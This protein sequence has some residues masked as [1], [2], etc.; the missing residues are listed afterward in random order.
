MLQRQL[1]HLN[2]VSLTTARFKPLILSMIINPFWVWVLYYDRRSVCL[3][4]K[5][6]SGAYDEIFI[7]SRQLWVCWC[8][9]LS[10]MRGRVCRWLLLLALA[11]FIFGSESHGTR[12]HIL[13]SQNRD[14]LFRRLLRLAGL[15]WRYSNPPPHGISIRS[16]LHGRLYSL[17]VT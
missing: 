4:I 3:G 15:R 13:L 7:T 12:D 5:H 10:L 6:P 11:I 2:V 1:S 16:Y 8:G 9:A 17:V 14:F